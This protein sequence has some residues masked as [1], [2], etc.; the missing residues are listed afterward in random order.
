MSKTGTIT[1]PSATSGTCY[2]VVLTQSFNPANPLQ[3]AAAVASGVTAGTQTRTYS[4]RR[5]ELC[6]VSC[7]LYRSLFR[8]AFRVT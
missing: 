3:N 2:A 6:A 7:A 5:T 1:L 4:F 8:R